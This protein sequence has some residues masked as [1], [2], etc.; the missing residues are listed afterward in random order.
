MHRRTI[1][2]VAAATAAVIALIYFLIGFGVLTVVT[3]TADDPSMVFFGFSAGGAFLLGAV[4]LVALDRRTLW[5]LGAILQLFVV[6]GYVAVAA[7][8]TPPFEFWGIALRI[9]QIPLF[10]ALVYLVVRRPVSASGRW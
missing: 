2:Y 7:D 9:I 3:P 10:A 8:R 5:I 6:W 4:L 1:R